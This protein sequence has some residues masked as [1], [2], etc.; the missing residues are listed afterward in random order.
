[1]KPTPLARKNLIDRPSRTVVSATGIGFA[2][3][4][5]FMQLGFMGAV[6]DTATNVYGRTN[7]DL[8][9]RSAEYLQAFDPRSL[10]SRLIPFLHSIAEVAEVQALDLGV[11]RWQNPVTGELRVVALMGIDPQNPALRLAELD[12]LAPLLSRPGY[13]L[14][15]RDSRADYGPQNRVR[16]G[17]R[18]IGVETEVSGRRV[19]IAGTFQ[20]GTGLAANGAILVSRDGFNRLA[21]D[22]ALL[23]NANE[24][25]SMILVRLNP[26]VSPQAGQAAIRRQLSQL[27][28]ASSGAQVLTMDQATRAERWHWYVETPIGLIF[29]MGVA[30]AVLVGG[31]ICYMVLAADI[32]SR[33][34]EYATLKAIGYSN[35]YLMKVLLG[36]AVW[37]AGVAFPPAVLAS[38]L[39]YGVTSLYSGIPIRM[40][41]DRVLLVAVLS[42]GM[43][44]IAGWIALRKMTKAEPANLF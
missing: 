43:C 20:M 11:G 29:G 33:L 32:I 13:V 14:V 26:G 28:G 35:A 10:P 23:P 36:Q 16:F 42:V 2:I 7:G 8:V 15:D 40:T 38:L 5:M 4:L 39:L 1:M 21:P 34:P 6:G 19:T 27:D 12:Q 31:V 44:G 24:R 9:I 18:D 37:L 3:V 41:V 17:E 25:V 30:L 22:R